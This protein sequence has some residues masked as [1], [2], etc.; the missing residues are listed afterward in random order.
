MIPGII[1]DK[2]TNVNT[3]WLDGIAM[4]PAPLSYQ[5][6]GVTATAVSGGSLTEPKEF[7]YIVVGVGI[8]GELIKN[9]FI[10]FACISGI[11]NYSGY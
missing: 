10:C 6:T 2:S 9:I 4:S 11:L 1:I 5:V 3:N 7:F 8:N